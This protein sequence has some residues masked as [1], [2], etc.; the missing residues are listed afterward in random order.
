[1]YSYVRL[2]RNDV[3]RG[4]KMSRM[5]YSSVINL[6]TL[7]NILSYPSLILSPSVILRRRDNQEE[8]IVTF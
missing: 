7:F 2:R 1:V 5:S 6:L 8:K 4:T 3:G